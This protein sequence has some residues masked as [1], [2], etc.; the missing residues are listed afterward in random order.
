M[1]KIERPNTGD[2]F[3]R[4]LGSQ[5]PYFIQ[6]NSGK[7]SFSVDLKSPAGVSLIRSLLPDV[8]VLVENLRPGKLEHVG[9]GSRECME[10]NPRLVY[11]SI[12]GFGE[13]GP[14]AN[15]PSYDTIGQAFS[16]LYSI[17]GDE[18]NPQLSGIPLA[19]LFTAVTAATGILASLVRVERIGQGQHL[20]TSIAEALTALTIDSFSQ[21][22]EDGDVKDP[23]RTSR[24]P[25]AQNFSLRAS[26]GVSIAIH[27]SSSESFWTSFCEAIGQPALAHDERFKDYF[28]R[29]EN[30]SV[31]ER[32]VGDSLVAHPRD[33]WLERLSEYDV[34]HSEV[35][36]IKSWLRDPQVEWLDVLEKDASLPL[37]RAPWRFDG[38]RPGRSTKTPI[39][40]QDTLSL[41]AKLVDAEVLDS[42]VSSGTL[43]APEEE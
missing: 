2:D 16:G 23:V 5:S 36:T 20:Q 27:L 41:A 37:V 31:L 30:Y 33:Y 3:R 38:V 7:K 15:A 32:I 18:D 11:A 43:F 28:S 24:H 9:L 14:R 10:V 39:V 13:G 12:T 6:Y 8:D 26:D 21:A 29:V 40:G 4:N 34:P 35:H 42:L 19:D 22:H 1:I 25:Q 17:L